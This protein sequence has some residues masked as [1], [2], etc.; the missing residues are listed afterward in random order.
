MTNVD[1]SNVDT[2]VCHANNLDPT[3]NVRGK[4]CPCIEEKTILDKNGKKKEIPNE[5][6][7]FNGKGYHC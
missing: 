3:T 4:M 5:K 7:H 1:K 2:T 6:G